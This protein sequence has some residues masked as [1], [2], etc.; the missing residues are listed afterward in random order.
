M[1]IFVEFN[2]FAARRYCIPYGA[3]HTHPA[4]T[5]RQC[6]ASR[7]PRGD[8][9]AGRANW[10]PLSRWWPPLRGRGHMTSSLSNDIE[11]SIVSH[12]HSVNEL[13]NRYT[14][15]LKYFSTSHDY[16][17]GACLNLDLFFY[18]VLLILFT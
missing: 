8:V 6:R 9:E 17:L 2:M 12:L 3:V 4:V 13:L 16:Y 1:P 11:Q 15:G 18:F 10:R 14:A 5:N 7:R